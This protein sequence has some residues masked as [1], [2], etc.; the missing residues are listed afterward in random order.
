MQPAYWCEREYQVAVKSVK[1]LGAGDKAYK[2]FRKEVRL[3]QNPHALSYLHGHL[4]YASRDLIDRVIGGFNL[5]A[6]AWM[7]LLS[8]D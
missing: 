2:K 1:D 4:H 6:I 8:V 5:L 3:E 7:T